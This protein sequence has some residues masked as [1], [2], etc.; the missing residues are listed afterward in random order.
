[1]CFICAPGLHKSEDM[2]LPAFN[3]AMWVK[4]HQPGMEK[5][6]NTDAEPGLKITGMDD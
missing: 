6:Q 2:V 4:T 5:A 1:M 3:V